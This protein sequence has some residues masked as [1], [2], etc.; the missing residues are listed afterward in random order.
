M[1]REE[2]IRLAADKY[3]DNSNNYMEWSDGW[4]D[5]TDIEYVESAFKAGVKWADEHPKDGLV[6]ID[7]VCEYLEMR[8]DSYII[9]ELRE[10]IKNFFIAKR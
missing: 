7:E 4:V 6:S 8:F 5:Y 10:A 1:T 3:S 2:L 9:R